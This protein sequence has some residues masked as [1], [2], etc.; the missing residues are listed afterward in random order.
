MKNL[1]TIV[2][3]V[4][5]LV[6]TFLMPI[7]LNSSNLTLKMESIEKVGGAYL[8]IADKFG[9]EISKKEIENNKTLGVEGC[10]KGSKI[11]KY[12][13]HIK[14]T[15]KTLT[16]KSDSNEL[17]SK[18]LTFIKGLKKG[19]TIIFKNVKAKL[20]TGELVDVHCRKFSIV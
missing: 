1:K 10:A 2:S 9:G 16:V 14:S 17:N 15:G 11:T 18:I 5:I 8:T 20:P 3:L 4:T 19:D 7:T 6:L 13:I 12:T